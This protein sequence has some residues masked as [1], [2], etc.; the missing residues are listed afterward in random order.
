MPDQPP[1]VSKKSVLIAALA[2]AGLLLAF[3][4]I[5]QNLT[6]GPP[7]AFDKKIIVGLRDPDDPSVPLGPAW[8][9][10]AARDL[11]SLGS[12]IVLMIITAAV[13]IYLFL[14][15]R[16]AAALLLLVAVIGGIALNDLLK[17]V[18]ARPRP[19]AVYQAARIFT[20]SFPSGHAELSA[21]TYLTHK[22]NAP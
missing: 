20:S 3:G 5:A 2:I 14:A 12:I 16:Y 21:I 22:P 7:L 9:Q 13:S 11:T 6:N 17:L 1:K 19:D 4:V 8:M 15:R 10:E 18:F